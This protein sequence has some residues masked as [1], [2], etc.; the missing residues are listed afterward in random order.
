MLATAHRG[1][2]HVRGKDC[3]HPEIGHQR[4]RWDDLFFLPGKA[5]NGHARLVLKH[6]RKR[7][8]S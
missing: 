2:T 3:V 4:L 6:G 1:A 7:S 5:D 8:S